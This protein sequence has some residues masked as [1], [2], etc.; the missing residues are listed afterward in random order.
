MPV[1][2]LLL[3]DI[4]L[5]III[6]NRKVIHEVISKSKK[7]IPIGKFK[8][9]CFDF[10]EDKHVHKRASN[11]FGKLAVSHSDIEVVTEFQLR[12]Q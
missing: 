11:N 8:K 9:W 4:I 7:T 5:W 1:A 12:I 6:L 2:F 3:Y 10:L